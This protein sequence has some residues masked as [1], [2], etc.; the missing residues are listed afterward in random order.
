MALVGE[1]AKGDVR[2]AD[3]LLSLII[4]AE[5]FE[6]QRPNA[7]PLSQAEQAIL[8]R[9]FANDAEPQAAPQ[10]EPGVARPE[11]AGQGDAGTNEEDQHG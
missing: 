4:Q 3:K 1:A 9:F 5:G 8:G 2:A 7:K 10:S 6:D 11:E